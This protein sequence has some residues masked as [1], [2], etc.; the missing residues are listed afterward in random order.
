MMNSKKEIS[1]EV[2][3]N[4][5]KK[6]VLYLV[7]ATLIFAIIGGAY[8][9]FFKDTTY[10]AEAQFYIPNFAGSDEY[11]SD[12]LLNASESLAEVCAV[13]VKK[14]DV[15]KTFAKD[16]NA[17]A[18]FKED[19]VN[20]VKILTSM[21]GSSS[22]G[23]GYFS[24]S[25]TSA[26]R[27]FAFQV[28]KSIQENFPEIAAEIVSTGEEEDRYKT[29]LHIVKEVGSIEE[30]SQNNPSVMKSAVLFGA[31]GFI[32]SYA[33]SLFVFLFD[34]KV[35][36]VIAVKQSFSEP[37]IATIPEWYTPEDK[38]QMRRS[39]SK[40]PDDDISKR[41]RQYKDKL[42]T[43]KTPFAVTESFNALRT[44]LS[45][46]T[47]SEKCTVFAITSDF[48]AAGKSFISANI[49]ISFAALGKRVLLVECDMRCPD[50]NRI[51]DTH[52]KI[53][54][55]EILSG[56][57]ENEKDGISKSE[58]DNFDIVY[59]GHIPPNPSELLGSS[60]MKEVMEQWKAE[61][62]YVILDM[63]PQIEVADAGIVASLVSGYLIVARTN[64]SDLR[65]ISDVVNN[66]KAVNG[67]I[68]GY[69]VNAVDIKLDGSGE[70]IKYDRY[71]KY[72]RYS[73]YYRYTKYAK[74]S[75]YH[76]YAL[77]ASYLQDAEN[78]ENKNKEEK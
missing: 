34:T 32:L 17:T 20:T 18:Y 5:L 47:S 62:D 33:I 1:I 23:K 39:R 7:L 21:I 65:A 46:A 10:T 68:I 28:I 4:V 38:K 75:K 78:G 43:K 66:L 42:L 44:N 60:K 69:I 36:D 51:F 71:S 29:K 35:H 26:D 73:K 6:A 40:I 56:N 59:S 67:N 70:S 76:Q 8:A 63:P 53:G 74:Y 64:H 24:V 30:I 50:F 13:L 22:L 31:V 48:S 61:Y 11:V 55:S 49:A 41:R 54:L 45:Y 15:V 27:E 19:M 57:I 72:S 9:N 16:V 3:I 12:T 37:V 77:N 25:V 14:N 52:V 58:F 2:L